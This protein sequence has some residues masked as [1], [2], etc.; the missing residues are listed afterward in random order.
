[1]FIVS[2]FSMTKS[3]IILICNAL[4]FLYLQVEIHDLK[5]LKIF[6]GLNLMELGINAYYLLR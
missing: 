5:T 2:L 6:M 1:M 4:L 3:E